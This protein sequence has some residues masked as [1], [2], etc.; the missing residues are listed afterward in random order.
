MINKKL[1]KSNNI[2]LNSLFKAKNF[3]GDSSK[4]LNPNIIPFIYGKRH[5]YSIINLKFVSYFLKRIFKLIQYRKKKEN[6]LIIGNSDDIKF[7]TDISLTK[8][9]SNITF[10]NEEWIHGLITNKKFFSTF[11]RKKF[12]MILIIKSSINENYLNTELLSLQIPIISFINT[13]QNLRNINYP[14]ITNSKNI[15]SLYMLIYLIR[16]II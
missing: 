3:Y 10:F 14:V 6:I 2:L 15:K 12:K 13:D 9:S 4:N 8:N 7:L 5:Q 11:R 16:K 1:K